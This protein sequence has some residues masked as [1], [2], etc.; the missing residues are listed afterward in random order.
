M[1]SRVAPPSRHPASWS[2]GHAARNLMRNVQRYSLVTDSPPQD[3]F[4]EEQLAAKDWQAFRRELRQ[5]ALAD[6]EAAK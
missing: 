6:R 3:H 1:A 4:T 2:Q 5:Q